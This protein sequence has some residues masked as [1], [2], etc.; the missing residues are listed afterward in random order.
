MRIEPFP[1]AFEI[2]L[3][4]AFK[5]DGERVCETEASS[6][7]ELISQVD[8]YD[9]QSVEVQHAPN[10]KEMFLESTVEFRR[11]HGY[12]ESSRMMSKA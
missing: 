4:S 8:P 7:G 5:C 2:K 11:Q 1:A 6:H 3:V 10:A 12:R 9:I